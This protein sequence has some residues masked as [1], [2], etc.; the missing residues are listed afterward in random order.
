MSDTATALLPIAQGTDPLVAR[1]EELRS[2]ALGGVGRGQGL[3]LFLR[4]GMRIWMEAPFQRSLQVSV[5]G[6]P[7]DG[8]PEGTLPLRM[9]MTMLL[10]SMVLHTRGR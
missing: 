8:Q 7:R 6:P 2:Q 1:Y 5:A 4:Q 10:A 9:E 3:A